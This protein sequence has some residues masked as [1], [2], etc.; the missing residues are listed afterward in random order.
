MVHQLEGVT[1]LQ[2]QE[3][4]GRAQLNEK[5]ADHV[6]A[7]QQLVLVAFATRKFP[8]GLG[9]LVVASGL[10]H[11]DDEEEQVRQ[12]LLQKRC[13]LCRRLTLRENQLMKLARRNPDDLKTENELVGD[14]FLKNFRCKKMLTIKQLKK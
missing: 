13:T 1:P 6:K 5:V 12:L 10:E 8:R 3:G 9:D 11:V 2:R 14:E 4:Q 7:V